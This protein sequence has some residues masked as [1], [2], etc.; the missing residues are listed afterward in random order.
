MT[1]RNVPCEHKALQVLPQS[2]RRFA[3]ELNNECY[4]EDQMFGS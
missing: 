4:Y 2:A 3:V 1:R